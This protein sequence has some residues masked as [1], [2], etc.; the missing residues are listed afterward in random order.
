MAGRVG[1][2]AKRVTARL[3]LALTIAAG[4]LGL[5]ADAA[6]AS[7]TFGPHDVRTV[8][9][10]AKSDDRNR[11]DYGIRLD[12]ECQ[13]VGA[14]PIYAYWHRFEPG[15]PTFGDLNYLDRQAYG[16]AS[17]RVRT[18]AE[19][20][21]WT[22]MRINAFPALRVLVLSQ[23]TASG[24]VARARIP[25]NSRPAFVDRVYVQLGGPFHTVEHVTFRGVDV[26]TERPVVERRRP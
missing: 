13:P 12:G 18:R 22:E 14:R 5:Q 17:Q 1:E 6:R 26:R 21:S 3:A 8:F 15:E 24:C 9:H 16:I 20:G 7:P 23:R 10:I 11:V 2:L 19:N 4:L 25:V